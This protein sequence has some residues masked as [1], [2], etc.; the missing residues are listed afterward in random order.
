MR[1]GNLRPG[2]RPGTHECPIRV[3]SGNA[4]SED[5][6]SAFHRKADIARCG[7]KVRSGPNPDIT[8]WYRFEAGSPSRR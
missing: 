8:D 6:E 5:I 4:R 7:W 2:F 3:M 1:R